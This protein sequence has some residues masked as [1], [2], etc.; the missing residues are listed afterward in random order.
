MYPYI[1]AADA[2]DLITS[3]FLGVLPH[4]PGFP[5]YWLLLRLAYLIPFGSIAL[6]ASLVSMFFG[7]ATACISLISVFELLKYMK[8]TSYLDKVIGLSSVILTYS[9]F[10]FLLYSSVQEVYTLSLFLLTLSTYF[11]L[12]LSLYERDKDH[13]LFLLV[14]LIACMH[15][16]LLAISFGPYLYIFIRN[17]KKYLK[18]Y[19]KYLLFIILFVCVSVAPY[20]L[21]YVLIHESALIYWEPKSIEGVVRTIFRM[22]YDTFNTGGSFGSYSLKLY[23]LYSYGAHLLA[24]YSI[25]ITFFLGGLLYLYK[26]QK[27][28]FYIFG[29]GYILFGP[30]L[31]FYMNT[32]G[33]LD[34]NSGILERYYLFSYVFLPVLFV[35]TYVQFEN[36]YFKIIFLKNLHLRKLLFKGI[37]ILFFVLYPTILFYRNFSNVSK[38]LSKPV[39]E[40]HAKNILNVVPHKSVI[41]LKG[42]LDLFTVEYAHHVLGVQKDVIVLSNRNLFN[43]D[44]HSLVARDYTK[45]RYTP[46]FKDPLKMADNLVMQAMK[47]GYSVFTNIPFPSEHY[48]FRRVGY[49]FKLYYS[50]KKEMTI[51]Q[52]PVSRVKKY[53]TL[54]EIV[55]S[56]FN[57]SVYFFT[58]LRNQYAKGL[59]EIAD[60]YY[61]LNNYKSANGVVDMAYLYQPY[62]PDIIYLRTILLK[63]TGKCMQSVPML[64]NYFYYS[65]SAKAAYTLSRVYA[66]CAKDIIKYSYWD[67]IYEKLR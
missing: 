6:R 18:F 51:A 7:I 65:K 25:L 22:R 62:N 57:P 23:H 40:D 45:L 53:N 37:V 24:N 26:K 58:E 44:Y 30:I 46:K 38:A 47:E 15:H 27:K 8:R 50:T 61:S 33:Q 32:S 67:S 13:L 66:I 2:G 36:M 16:T 41:I 9:S 10:V 64:T 34:N 59:L 42:D 11:L 63:N 60:K 5:I 20:I 35:A 12:K 55:Y 31:I 43:P 17:K 28:I 19:R 52:I 29:L 21:Q 3:S 56:N 48:S 39:F 49:L 54:P 4:P 1:W 14:F